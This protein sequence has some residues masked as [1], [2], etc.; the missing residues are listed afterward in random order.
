VSN[1]IGGLERI[2]VITKFGFLGDTI[3]AT[4]FLRRLREA[5]PNAR[6][7]L[8]TGPG[9]PELLAGCPYVD[10]IKTLD[11]KAG[12][13]L[14]G[15]LTDAAAI[16][17]SRY[18]AAFVLN[19]SIHSAILTA[20]AGIPMRVGHDTE[21]RGFSLTVRVPYDWNKPDREC[22]LDLL[23]A[24]GAPA[25]PA[26][27]QLWVTQEES[28]GARERLHELSADEDSIL[29][30]MQ[31]GANDAYVREWGAQRFATVADRL[32]EE[33]GARIVL[34]GGAAERATSDRVASTMQ[35]NPIVLTGSTGLREVL[36]LISL[37]RLWIGNDG[38]LLH[39]A[40][41]LGV[42]TVGIFGPT[43]ARRWG[44]EGGCHR[45]IAV[46]PPSPAR[47]PKTIRMCLD[48]ITPESVYAAAQELIGAENCIRNTE[49]ESAVS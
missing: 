34:F 23:R 4:P 36:A 41:A 45:T 24:V 26:M 1:L 15:T 28:D 48:A 14:A 21:L 9:I 12:R 39:A 5:A 8:L 43:K 49:K 44:Y 42:P 22:A 18:D 30:G 16:R 29:V 17:A 46:Y 40:A 19:R 11:R 31:P 13:A 10:E 37:C 47:D 35:E 7:T 2:L 3:V 20:L 33:Y 6:I 25:D 32:A 27:P 38:G